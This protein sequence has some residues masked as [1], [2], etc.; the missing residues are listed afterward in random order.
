[1][2]YMILLLV[3]EIVILSGGYHEYTF[4]HFY[5]GPV[6][7]SGSLHD[8]IAHGLATLR[9]A[10]CGLGWRPTI[11]HPTGRCCVYWLGF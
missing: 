2:V 1:M 9:A 8:W 10:C 5:S 6:C 3:K 11:W 7:S 4:K